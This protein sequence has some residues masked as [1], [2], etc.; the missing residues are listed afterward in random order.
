MLKT[1]TIKDNRIAD[2]VGLASIRIVC[3]NHKKHQSLVICSKHVKS[4][5]FICANYYSDNL[6][7]QYSKLSLK[8]M[9]EIFASE[10][11]EKTTLEL[12]CLHH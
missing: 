3:Y 1:L 8:S 2:L 10:P 5:S 11:N 12:E 6:I 7:L 4:M 9:Y